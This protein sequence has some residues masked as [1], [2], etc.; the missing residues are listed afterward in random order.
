MTRI[1]IRPTAIG[2]SITVVSLNSDTLR[3]CWAALTARPMLTTLQ[4]ARCV[5]ISTLTA[6]MA[7]RHLEALGYIEY[8]YVRGVRSTRTCRILVP[9]ATA[10]RKAVRR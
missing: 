10:Q 2:T 8:A 6:A 3:A 1:P 5:G 9:L 7:V 4:L